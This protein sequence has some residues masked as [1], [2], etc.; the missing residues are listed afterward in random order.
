MAKDQILKA[1]K[2]LPRLNKDKV[3][4]TI[5]QG[6]ATDDLSLTSEQESEINKRLAEIN[7]SEIELLDGQEAMSNMKK[8][9]T[10]K[11]VLKF[12]LKALQEF[13][14]ALAYYHGISP[15]VSKDFYKE[16]IGIYL[17]L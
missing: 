2:K 17:L 10:F 11:V 9:M 12:H 8:S 13:E 14:E 6:N 7:N 5:V 3:L 16:S 4:E 15:T 1:V